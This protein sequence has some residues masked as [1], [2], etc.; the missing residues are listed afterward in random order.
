[1]RGISYFVGVGLAAVLL[2]AGPANAQLESPS[3]CCDKICNA[4]GSSTRCDAL[5]VLD[6]EAGTEVVAGCLDVGPLACFGGQILSQDDM[7]VTDGCACVLVAPDLCLNIDVPPGMLG[8]VQSAD[9][10]TEEAVAGCERGGSVVTNPCD[11]D[12]GCGGGGGG[13]VCGDGVCDVGEVCP[14][15]CDTE[16]N[17][18]DGVDNDGDGK[19]DCE[20]RDCFKNRSGGGDD[21]NPGGHGNEGGFCNPGGGSNSL[22]GL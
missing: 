21:T 19:T 17:C 10:C 11:P 13:P 8:Q 6:D 16:T 20:D 1:M 14:E 4:D 12:C 18:G 22:L 7:V 9:E 15:D 3:P 5:K 2:L